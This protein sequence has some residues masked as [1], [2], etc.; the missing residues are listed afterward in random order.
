ML[1]QEAKSH[2][3]LTRRESQPRA[4]RA[5]VDSSLLLME[6]HYHAFMLSYKYRLVLFSGVQTQ[7]LQSHTWYVLIFYEDFLTLLLCFVLFC[8]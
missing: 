6:P 7:K 2:P 4:A 1:S 3:A 5:P 8:V